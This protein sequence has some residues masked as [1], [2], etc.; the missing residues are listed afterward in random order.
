MEGETPKMVLTGK[1]D[2]I[3]ALG[4]SYLR[5]A[6]FAALAAET[7][8]KRRGGYEDVEVPTRPEVLVADEKPRS[9]DPTAAERMRRYRNKHRNDDRN[10]VTD[11][12]ELRLVNCVDQQQEVLRAAE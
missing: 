6:A 5:S 3:E 9:K 10:T 2:S 11:E 7:K 4:R 8:R 1:H 12:P